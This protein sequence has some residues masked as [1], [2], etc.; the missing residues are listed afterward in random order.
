M[1][2][3]RLEQ[4][5]EQGASRHPDALAAVCGDVELSYGQLDR[6]ANALAAQLL[7]AG[8]RPGD[9][10]GLYMAKGVASLVALYGVLKTGA[11][12]VPL[13]PTGPLSRSLSIARR[14]GMRLLLMGLPQARKLS[15]SDHALDPAGVRR[16]VVLCDKQIPPER[17]PRLPGV[18]VQLLPI[19]DAVDH[20]PTRSP[21][22]PGLTGSAEDTAYILF[23]SGSTGTPKGVTI[24]HRS[25]LYFVRWAVDYVGLQA[26]DRCSNHAPLFFDLSIFD[27]YATMLAGATVVIVPPAYS[28]FPRSLANYLEQQQIS[29]WYSVPSTLMDLLAAGDLQGRTL[30]LRAVVFAG[31]V[32]PMAQLRQLMQTLPGCGHFYNLYGP[33]ETNVCTAHRLPGLPPPEAREIPIGEVCEGLRWMLLGEDGQPAARGAEG[34]LLIA[35]PAVMQGYWGMPEETALVML[36]RDGESFYRTGDLVRE[37]ENGQ[38]YFVGR[39]DSMVKISGYRVEL[40]EVEAAL[41]SIPGVQEGCAVA[42]TGDGGKTR[43]VAFVTAPGA[44]LDPTTVS[45]GLLTRLPN[46]MMPEQIRVLEAMPRTPTGK[47]D[48]RQLVYTEQ[49]TEDG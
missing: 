1:T 7:E 3:E 22:P 48:R 34:E 35:G 28:A 47:I 13:D 17:V 49:H 9:R 36:Q 5:L 23:T 32:F 44:G 41:G 20:G 46:Y 39:K 10:V 25:S 21:A 4:I 31:E 37:H 8:V 30:Q 43:L 33:T 38:L 45:D 19:P 11:A 27:I 29:V 18:Q 14:C 16:V 2:V 24:S 6:A 40:G 15:L 12:Y 42:L 26:G